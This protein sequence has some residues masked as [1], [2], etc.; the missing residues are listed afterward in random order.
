MPTGP[1]EILGAHLT[2]SHAPNGRR[3]ETREPHHLVKRSFKR[4][5]RRE[6][7]GHK[8]NARSEPQF[9]TAD[10]RL[11]LLV[12][13]TLWHERNLNWGPGTID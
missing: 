8:L 7:N 10:R 6:T 3:L 5:Q 1:R 4:L 2:L 9:C 11:S 12:E 13:D